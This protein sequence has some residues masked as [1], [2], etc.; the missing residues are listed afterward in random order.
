[1]STLLRGLILCF[2]GALL[3][4][5]NVKA[6]ISVIPTGHFYGMG[7]YSS[8]GIGLGSEYTVRLHQRRKYSRVFRAFGV[9]LNFYLPQKLDDRYTVFATANDNGESIPVEVNSTLQASHFSFYWKQFLGDGDIRT[10][11]RWYMKFGLGYTLLIENNKPGEYDQSRYTIY[12]FDPK[13]YR[14]GF[15]VPLGIGGELHTKFG[16]FI[17]E[18]GGWFAQ[19]RRDEED[20]ATELTSGFQ[21]TLGYIIHLGRRW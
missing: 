11:H 15:V 3:S 8:V 9:D 21:F 1:M 13:T 2:I 7:E 12:F 19:N 20:R 10:R 6:Q 18:T 16:N 17:W 14:Y 5:S 4:N